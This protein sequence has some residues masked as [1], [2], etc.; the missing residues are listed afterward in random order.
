MPHIAV[1]DLDGTLV[2]SAPAIARA[3]DRLRGSRGMP[4]IDLTLVRESVSLGAPGLV[5]HALGMA[6]DA[7]AGDVARFRAFYSEQPG[8]QEDLYPGIPEALAQLQ[9]AGVVMGIATNKP[10]ALSEKVLMGAGIAAYFGAVV[11]GDATPQPKPHPAHLGQVLDLLDWRGSFDFVGDSSIDAAAARAAGARFLW[12][13]WGYA[14]ASDLANSDQTLRDPA[15][16]V[17]AV[18]GKERM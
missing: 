3:L 1:F 11:G 16:L 10:Q 2:D 17:A 4:P 18:L 9:A 13:A 15:D 8:G 6:G 7:G 5:G 14:D 12:A